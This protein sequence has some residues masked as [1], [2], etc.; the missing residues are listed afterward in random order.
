METSGEPESQDLGAKG[1]GPGPGPAATEAVRVDSQVAPGGWAGG[2]EKGALCTAPKVPAQWA[3]ILE[4]RMLGFS[5][6][7]KGGT[8]TACLGT[9]PDSFF[10]RRN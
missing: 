9:E 10:S 4:T 7:P 8:G 2:R 1:E 5:G 3:Q 6:D